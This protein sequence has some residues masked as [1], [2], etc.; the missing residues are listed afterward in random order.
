MCLDSR[1]NFQK[2]VCYLDLE[3][4]VRKEDMYLK[5]LSHKRINDLWPIMTPT[6]SSSLSIRLS[7]PEFADLS[8]Q[9]QEEPL[10]KD[11]PGR[12]VLFPIEDTE[13]SGV[14]Y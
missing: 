11:N 9:F 4:S 14:F 7:M 13:V 6:S 3:I 2:H 1:S 12:F 5:H 8:G 10:L